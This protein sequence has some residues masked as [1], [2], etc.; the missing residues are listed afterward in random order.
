M[1]RF[2][3]MPRLATNYVILSG[4]EFISKVLAAVALAYLA[5]V[6]GPKSYGYLEF[7]IA[8]YFIV[9]LFVDSGLSYI[10]AREIAKDK[11]QLP[12]LFVNITLAR[13]ILAV[14][15]FLFLALL[16][17][18]INQPQEVKT[19]I[20]LYGLVMLVLPWL[21]QYVFQGRD[22]MQYVALASLTRWSVF[23]GLVFLLVHAPRQIWLVPVIEG[24]AQLSVG[25]ILLAAIAHLFGLPRYRARLKEAF[26]LYRKALPIGASELVWAVKIYFATILLGFVIG[27]EELGW[28]AA[29]HRIVIA[30]HAFVWLYF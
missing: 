24:A 6:L 17:A 21:T 2:L 19:L 11:S 5:R 9:H 29:A 10:G 4:G 30:L 20:F 16:A 28:F 23:A 13:S 15:A 18:F 12:R 27:G 1:Q 8:I 14:T 7:A 25:V 22:M 3:R 26:A